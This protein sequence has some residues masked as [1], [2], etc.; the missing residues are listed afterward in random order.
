MSS[1]G[2]AGRVCRKGSA[3]VSTPGTPQ[4]PDSWRPLC[5]RTLRTGSC[6][7][8][9]PTART[10][11]PTPHLGRCCSGLF[12]NCTWDPSE[13]NRLGEAGSVST[14]PFIDTGGTR[15]CPDACLR[16]PVK[17]TPR[18]PVSQQAKGPPSPQLP[19][20]VP[21]PC[22][23]RTPRV[24]QACS[25]WDRPCHFSDEQDSL[26]GLVP[27]GGSG[28][29]TGRPS[30]RLSN[31]RTQSSHC[32]QAPLR[33]GANVSAKSSRRACRTAND[34]DAQLAPPGVPGLHAGAPEGG[35]RGGVCLQLR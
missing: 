33:F 5:P 25:L 8:A 34:G 13:R 1:G 30:L 4:P 23:R 14:H 31:P 18:F 21:Q 6:E 29:H 35:R 22:P 11:P 27:V 7:H 10:S 12:P 16:W 15:S 28:G 20:H 24:P 9:P 32:P 19:L 17:D 26:G 2:P 3:A